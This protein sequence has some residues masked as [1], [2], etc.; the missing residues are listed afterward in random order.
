MSLDGRLTQPLRVRVATDQDPAPI[1]DVESI[2]VDREAETVTVRSR[3]D[4]S[5]VE[6]VFQLPAYAERI[7]L[8]SDST[9]FCGRVEGEPADKSIEVYKDENTWPKWIVGIIAILALL[10]VLRVLR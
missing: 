9:I 7:V 5:A 6:Q 1:Y 3:K 2:E 8:F 10:V 4:S